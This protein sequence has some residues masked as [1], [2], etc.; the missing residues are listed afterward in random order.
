MIEKGE[1]VAEDL[2]KR[3]SSHD[4]DDS[5]QGH[6][7]RTNKQVGD[8]ETQDEIVVV[9][10]EFRS[11]EKRRDDEKITDDGYEDDYSYDDR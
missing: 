10:A 1:D 4:D 3:P 11:R 7:H 5:E 8:G 2:A 9:S 6:V